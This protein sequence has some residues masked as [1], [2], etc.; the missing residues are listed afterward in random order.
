LSSRRRRSNPPLAW[1]ATA[2]AVR[3]LFLD[4]SLPLAD[5]LDEIFHYSY[6]AFLAET[7][8][9]PRAGA[10]SVPLEALGAFWLRRSAASGAMRWDRPAAPAS[11]LR[12][13]GRRT[14]AAPNY[15]TQHPPLFYLPAAALL[16]MTS[17]LSLEVRLFLLRLFAASCALPAVPAAYVFFRRLL[18]RRTA[19]VATSALVALP[20]VASLVGR[21][22]NDALALPLAVI[23][24]GLLVELSRGRLSR[25]GAAALTAVLA[26]GCWTKL[27]FLP[28]L[29]APPA[30]AVL[31]PSALR[32]SMLR[33]AAASSVLAAVL[34]V[35]WLVRQHADTG[36]W[37]GLTP[38][39]AAVA[40]H[41]GLRDR[42]AAVP[43]IFRARYWVVFGRTFL[44]P[45]T[46]SAQGAP[47]LVSAA[48]TTGLVAV[49]LS[50]L[51]S[52]SIASLR[53]RR[54]ALAS[55]MLLA[56]FMIAE[57]LYTNT[58]TAVAL[59]RGQ[60]DEAYG[61]GW[62][63]AILTP[64]VLVLGCV[65]GR[66]V[67]PGALL[68]LIA[69]SI[70]AA[71]ILD[72]GVLPAVYSGRVGFNGANAPFSTYARGVV[73]PAAAMR[74]YAASGLVAAPAA[75][76]AALWIGW[77]GMLGIALRSRASRDSR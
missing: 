22:T 10:P 70:A 29:A 43:A 65:R 3:L 4:V 31:A 14:F 73:R 25:R 40:V 11:A 71:W 59:A 56:L 50:P 33:R 21:F 18:S 42:L 51:V 36:D 66:I 26:A 52:G 2:F 45:G 34:F 47:A 1:I 64:A 24:L 35:P 30:A 44:W 61:L 75:V 7:G 8:R 77:Q 6:A 67:A 15:Q 5:P 49:W 23:L 17:D 12:D 53:V 41:L 19:I 69:L 48:L 16:R 57:L 60:P 32:A 63:A 37:L 9:I 54:G 58:F 62:Y 39:K 27:S 28:F 20:G 68:A 76:I 46:G 55:G 74:T 38:S 72:L 13:A